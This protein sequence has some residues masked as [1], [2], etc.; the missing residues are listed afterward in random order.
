M[1]QTSFSRQLIVWIATTSAC[2]TLVVSLL[3]WGI[4]RQAL[5]ATTLELNQQVLEQMEKNLATLDQSIKTLGM[6]VFASRDS[7][8]LLEQ[9]PS[10]V[11]L[12]DRLQVLNTFRLANI[13]FNPLIHSIYFFNYP[14]DL[15]YVTP[16]DPMVEDQELPAYLKTLANQPEGIRPFLRTL[17]P[18]NLKVISYVLTDSAF[19]PSGLPDKGIVINLNLARLLATLDERVFIFDNQGQIVDDG[20]ETSASLV[21]GLQKVALQNTAPVRLKRQVIDGTD[22]MISLLHLNLM[23]W[24]LVKIKPASL[25]FKQVTTLQLWIA[26]FT[27]LGLL[28]SIGVSWLIGRRLYRPLGQLLTTIR[29][30]FQDS[31]ADQNNPDEFAYL[32]AAYQKALEQADHTSATETTN[33]QVL[34][35]YFLTKLVHHSSEITLEE[36]LA[37]QK[38]GVMLDF[39]LPLRV[40]A[41]SLE[42]TG[43]SQGDSELKV[44]LEEA[45]AGKPLAL[46]DLGDGI[47][48][49][50]VNEQPTEQSSNWLKDC[51]DRFLERAEHQGFTYTVALSMVSVPAAQAT[52]ATS[53]ALEALRNGRL[54]HKGKIIDAELVASSQKHLALVQAIRD[55]VQLNYADVNLNIEM[56]AEMLKVSAHY[57][58]RVFRS[59]E[60]QSFFDFLTEVRLERAAILLS[61]PANTVIKEVMDQVG[62]GNVSHFYKAFKNRFGMTPRDHSIQAAIK[63]V[64]G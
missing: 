39:E 30:K 19:T 61:Q 34:A 16:G 20:Q 12:Y 6:S 54:F 48:I 8:Q 21:Q 57:L 28:G 22:Y 40:V 2:L 31:E 15:H 58:A 38:A 62:M 46:V 13:D 9:V 50:V 17:P 56:V 51:F 44:R 4:S 25:V 14:K 5:E 35:K 33:A 23:D 63:T 27:V 36:C 49:L 43:S 3:F 11:E 24:T 42:I 41:L 32:Q 45:F 64:N 53:H 7:V 52:M 1:K 59:L 18:D 10:R 60:G 55:I 37:A 29:G 26:V 47:Q